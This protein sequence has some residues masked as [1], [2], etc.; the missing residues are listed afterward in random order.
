MLK[1]SDQG[2]GWVSIAVHWL[3]AM[4]IFFMFGLGLYMVEL[5][6]YDAWYKGSLD[7]HKSLGII[8]IVLWLFR[9]A[10]RQLNTKPKVLPGPK[11]EQ[12]AA[13]VG[14]QLLYVL[15]LLLLLSGYFISTADGRPISVFELFE[16]PALPWSFDNQEDILG[17]IHF[18]LAWSLI[19][20][21][22]VHMLAALKHQFIN[23]DGGLSR[24]LKVSK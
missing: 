14:H 10:W 24:I 20:F 22:V 16:I 8:L 11:L 18:W 17:D 23:K 2:Y 4:V 19:G 3:M 13:R 6:Y 21:V 15:M 5:T 12:I 7:L 9:L 1:N